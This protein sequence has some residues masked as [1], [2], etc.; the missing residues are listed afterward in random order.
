M[1]RRAREE[2]TQLGLSAVGKVK[3]WVNDYGYSTTIGRKEEDGNYTNVYLNLYF[4]KDSKK[5]DL[6]KNGEETII[7]D[8]FFFVVGREGNER[9]ALYVKNWS[10]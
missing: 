1:S 5:E 10:Y 6:P 4:P 8:S 3:V 7:T 9:L 2:K